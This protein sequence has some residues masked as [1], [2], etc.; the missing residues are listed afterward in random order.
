MTPGGGLVGTVVRVDA[1]QCEVEL[2]GRELPALLRGRLFESARE[3][4]LP[5]AVGD[6][7]RLAQEGEEYAIEEVLPRRNFFARRAAG[8][9]LRRQILAAN[10]DQVV[11][12][13]SF[14]YPP[15]SS[16][17]ADRILCAAHF[18]DIPAVLVLNKTD[19]ARR[20][21]VEAIRATYEAAGYRVLPTSAKRGE[22]IEE[23]A[24][25]LRDRVSVF[26]GLSGTGKSSLLNCIE[27]GL[28]LRTREVSAALRSGRHTTTFARLYRLRMGGAVID[29]PGVRVFRPYGIP[30]HELRLHFPEF[31]EPGRRCRFPACLHREEPDC[32]VRA[33]VEAGELPESRWRSYLEILEELEEVF[34]GQGTVDD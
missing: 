1:R 33:A 32:A 5:V 13:C 28:G 31:V 21:Q 6:R 34:G 10:V 25:C 18:H 9:D 3:D 19:K 16:V 29:T 27:P 12:V 2:D 14:G 11:C 15:F 8:E 22:G 20:R 17:T 7:V 24:A 4:R 30:P 23:L 26:Y